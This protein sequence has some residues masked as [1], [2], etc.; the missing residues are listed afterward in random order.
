MYIIMILLCFFFNR[1]LLDLSHPCT[2]LLILVFGWRLGCSGKPGTVPKKYAKRA[3][4]FISRTLAFTSPIWTRSSC[5]SADKWQRKTQSDRLRH[6]QWQGLCGCHGWYLLEHLAGRT[7]C[8]DKH[9]HPFQVSKD[10]EFALC[11]STADFW[12]IHNILYSVV[13]YIYIYYTHIINVYIYIWY[14]YIYIYI[15]IRNW[16]GDWSIH[17]KLAQIFSPSRWSCADVVNGLQSFR[18]M[19]WYLPWRDLFCNVEKPRDSFFSFL[20]P[21]GGTWLTN[22]S[23]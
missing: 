18:C 4:R 8:L 15:C 14:V 12:K 1:V 11:S 17:V 22:V 19:R 21:F 13:T 3:L 2:S 23:A 6:C 16:F 5:F 20:L 10:R 9:N 7:T